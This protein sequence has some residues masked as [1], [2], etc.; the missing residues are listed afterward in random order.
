MTMAAKQPLVRI[1]G[2]KK[3]RRELRRAEV[4]MSDLSKPYREAAATVKT[5]AVPAAPKR[6][7]RLARTVRSSGTRTAGII[8]AGS[9][10]VPYAGAIH[11]GWPARRIEAQ[12]WLSEAAQR[13]EPAWLPRFI[14]HMNDVLDK[15]KGLGR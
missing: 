12:P 10:S 8:R 2:A 11:W 15:I 13:T 1:D 3:M 4:D 5:A 7:G 6:S 9:N 14:D